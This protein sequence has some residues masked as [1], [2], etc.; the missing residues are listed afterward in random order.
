[1]E[2]LFGGAVAIR[3]FR[4]AVPHNRLKDGAC[5]TVVQS[6]VS[7]RQQTTQSATPQRCSATPTRADI[8]LHKQAMLY[9]I[10]IGPY[11]LVGIFRQHLAGILADALGVGLR[12]SIHPH[13]VLASLP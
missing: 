11:G 12:G 3:L 5:A 4:V 13:I 9:H 7:T 1:M 10:G 2:E 6:V 8:V